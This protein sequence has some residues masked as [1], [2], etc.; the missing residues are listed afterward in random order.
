MISALTSGSGKTTI[1]AALLMLLKR[2]GYDVT[3][4]K[5]GP[6]YID[7]LFHKLITKDDEPG[8]Q[9]ID[10]FLQG[11]TK[12]LKIFEGIDHDMAV[13]EGAMGFYDGIRGTSGNSAYD[14]AV[15]LGIPVI[16]IVKPGGSSLTLAA[17]IRGI[18]D[19]RSPMPVKGIILNDCKPSLYE[20]LRPVIER[21]CGIK[22]LGYVPHIEGAV[23]ESRHLGLRLTDEPKDIMN[24]LSLVSDAIEEHVDMDLLMEIF[25]DVCDCVSEGRKKSAEKNGKNDGPENSVRIAVAYDRAFCFYYRSSL[26]ALKKAGAELV[27][28]SPLTDHKLPDNIQG[29]YIGGGYPELYL[30]ELSENK[31][32]LSDVKKRVEE[33]LP[34][35]F[36]CGGFIYLHEQVFDLRGESEYGMVGFVK[37]KASCSGSLKNFGY[38]NIR[39]NS[40]DDNMLFRPD[41]QIPAHEF[42]YYESDANGDDLI[43]LRPKISEAVCLSD[44]KEEEKGSL[45]GYSTGSLYAGFP[46]LEFSGEI[47]LAERFTERAREYGKKR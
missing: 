26:N 41:E 40:S 46:H 2:R 22:V 30:K 9:N 17:M 16:L 8:G 39:L 45:F 28:F 38:K 32:M 3:G 47:P 15:S 1:T 18:L 29:L 19:F 24:R 5:C 42:H 37:G 25:S 21:E 23:I 34:S 10:F 6:D 35:V 36:E 11:K 44:R 12:A 33:G 31:E 20:H 14:I 43:A 27:Y 13:A 4:I 7:P